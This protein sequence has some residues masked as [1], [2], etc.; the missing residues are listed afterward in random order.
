MSPPPNLDRVQAVKWETPSQGGTQDDQYPTGINEIQDALSARGFYAQPDGGPAD[1]EVL[2][3]RDGDAWTFQD[4]QAGPYTLAG[5]LTIEAHKALR[6]LIH[7]IEEGPAEGFASGA[8]KEVTGQPF[9][10]S[11]IWWESAAKLKKIV[12]KTITRTGGSATN[13][14]PT[15][16]AYK[17]Y[18]ADGTTV[19]AEVSDAITYDGVFEISRTRTIT[20][21]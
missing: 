20:V 13:V 15:P 2:I 19:V 14:T 17:V 5:L 21:Y 3:W 12:E 10:T 1:E 18:A 8:Y 11:I 4:K 16:I 6:Q 9:P 7:F